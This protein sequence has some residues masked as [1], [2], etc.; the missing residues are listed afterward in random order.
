MFAMKRYAVMPTGEQLRYIERN[1]P[2]PGRKMRKYKWSDIFRAICYVVKTGCLWHLFLS[3]HPPCGT[4][5]HHF[6]S[7]SAR[8]WLST[9]LKK[10]VERRRREIGKS[11]PHIGVIDSR[12]VRGARYESV[13][14]IDG[15]KKI[16]GIKRHI[17]TDSNGY[18]LGIHVTQANVSDR[19]A[20]MPMAATLREDFPSV[21]RIK[22]DNGYSGSVGKE[23]ASHYNMELKC[24]KSNYGTSAFVPLDG[25]WVVERT[26]SWLDSY[27][28]ICCNYGK[29]LESATAMTVMACLMFMLRYVD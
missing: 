17:V 27:R 11:A 9:V 8:G 25:R 21:K 18:P 4:V 15:G 26:F 23:L 3:C 12:S 20:V 7:W 10:L 22:A 29:T 19:N 16:K 5:Y 2:P 14:G 28:R 1:I 13:K 24:V 6:R